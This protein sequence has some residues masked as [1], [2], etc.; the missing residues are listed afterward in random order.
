M[1]S[2]SLWLEEKFGKELIKESKTTIAN[3][4]QVVFGSISAEGGNRT[5]IPYGTRF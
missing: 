5:H 2:L 4:R 1:Y 3:D